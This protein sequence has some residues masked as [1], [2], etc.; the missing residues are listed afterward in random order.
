MSKFDLI[1]LAAVEKQHILDV[2]TACGGNKARAARVLGI[3]R[4][5]MYKKLGEYELQEKVKSETTER[6]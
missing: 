6:T 3:D 1:P 2:F 5:T 4:S